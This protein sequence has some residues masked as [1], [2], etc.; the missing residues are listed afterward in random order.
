MNQPENE[1][2]IVA[3]ET[4]CMY[5]HRL[6]EKSGSGRA[7]GFGDLQS[8]QRSDYGRGGGAALAHRPR[9]SLPPNQNR[10]VLGTSILRC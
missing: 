7:A 5:E 1:R 6:D 3:P 9:S 10:Q 4:E 2:I 8:P